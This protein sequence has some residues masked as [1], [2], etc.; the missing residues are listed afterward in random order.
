[1]SLA[2][3]YLVA[4][5]NEEAGLPSLVARLRERLAEFPGSEVVLC[6]NGSKDGSLAVAEKLAAESAAVRIT[7]TT[8]AGLGHG[9]AMGME[10]VL[11]RSDAHERWIVLT[12][13]D[14]PFDFSDLDRFLEWRHKQTDDP[15]A[16]LVGSKA[17]PD[18]SRQ[19]DWKRSVAT[20]GFRS[21]RTVILQMKT[22]DPQGTFF[23][24][25]GVAERLLPHIIARNYFFTTELVYFAERAGIPVIE[26]PVVFAGER[27]A[28]TVR[29]WKHGSQMAKQTLALRF[30]DLFSGT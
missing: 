3:S 29:I 22:H 2:F 23:V 30:R 7:T 17:H 25:R 1:V 12:A 16:V 19:R 10:D 21:L 18:T 8:N 24:A 28:S 9:L 11:A 5:H 27:R 13:A 20:F 4:V 26:I 6:E 14:L 15:R